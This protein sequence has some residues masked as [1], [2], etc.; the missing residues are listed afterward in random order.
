MTHS[1]GLGTPAAAARRGDLPTPRAA[2]RRAR[3]RPSA[4]RREQ[5]IDRALQLVDAGGLHHVTM[6][7]IAA[8]LGVS[9][10]AIYRHVP[11]RRALVLGLMD[12]LDA[13]LLAPIRTIAADSARTRDERLA[14]VLRHHVGVVLTHHSLPILLLAEASASGD[15]KLVGRMRQ[16][17]DGYVSV[18]RDLI[19]AGTGDPGPLRGEAGALALVFLGVP[20]AL[21]IQN[22]L[23]PNPAA[24][25]AAADIVIPRILSCLDLPEGSVV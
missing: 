22:R 12:R 3:P 4:V 18:L 15:R 14:A 16:I 23:D 20:S 8:R 17:F 1:P 7:R 9:E 19:A 13:L 6:K 25:R 24:A 11:S 21:A 10:A 5:I 2:S